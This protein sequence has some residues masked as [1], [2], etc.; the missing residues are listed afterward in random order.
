MKGNAV[1]AAVFGLDHDD[2]RVTAA[3]EAEQTAYQHYGVAYEEHFFE[4]SDWEARL[5]VVEAGTG[6]PVVLISGGE[7]MGYRMLPLVAELDDY[8]VYLMD[9]PGG[10]LSDGIDPRSVPLGRQAISSTAV[11]FDRFD[12]DTAPVVGN[13]MGGFWALHFALERPERVAAIASLGSPGFYPG[14][15]VPLPMRLMSLPGIGPLLVEQLLQPDDADDARHGLEQLGHPSETV[16][17]L[18]EAFAEG[19]YRMENLPHFDRSWARLLRWA[20]SIT[21]W[22]G[23]D[24][25]L[26][27]TPEELSDVSKP[28]LLCWGPN[29]PF[30]GV[31]IGRAGAEYIPDA[32]FHE[33]GSGHLPWLDKPA[34]CG[35]LLREFLDRQE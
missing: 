1:Q 33:V 26:E 4:L 32:E 23:F 9:R 17:R 35:R 30:A 2:P 27:F 18:P 6:P 16:E 25:D 22:R 3:R 12:I 31:D 8:T 10:G 11:L 20:V 14:F 24:P 19:L 21:R 5:R 34:E 13:S 15:S 29:D 7:G 28:V